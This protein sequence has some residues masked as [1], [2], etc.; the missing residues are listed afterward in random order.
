MKMMI[1]IM[2][3]ATTVACTHTQK[4]VSHPIIVDTNCISSCDKDNEECGHSAFAPSYELRMACEH[5][6]A[7]CL[8]KC[9]GYSQIVF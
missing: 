2:I 4:E 1:A 7:I 9:S 8:S 3:V 5:N 6:R